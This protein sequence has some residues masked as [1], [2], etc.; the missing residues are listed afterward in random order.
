MVRY[1]YGIILGLSLLLGAG[2]MPAWAQQRIA[3]VIGN[4]D[5]QLIPA[6]PNPKNDAEL[7]ATTLRGLDFEVVLAIDVDG[8]A[9]SRAVRKFGKRLRAAGEDAVGLFF[10]AGHGVAARGTNFL[11]PLGAEIETESDLELESLSASSILSQ[12][13]DARNA[14][15]LVILDACRNNP[16]KSAVRS[17]SGGLARV[18]SAS[19]SLIAFSA[20]PGQVAVDGDGDNSPYTKALV[21]AMQVPGIAIEQVFKRTR[22][23]VEEVTGGQQSPWEE[24]SLRGDFYFVP[25]TAPQAN[26]QGTQSQVLAPVVRDNTAAQTE[27]LFWQSVKDSRDPD[28]FAAYLE[29]Y[30]KGT[31][32]GL[33]RVLMNNLQRKANPASPDDGAKE[34]NQAVASLQPPAAQPALP[35]ASAPISRAIPPPPLPQKSVRQRTL[36]L[37][38]GLKR[39]GCRPGRIDGKWGAKGRRA[40]SRFKRYAGLTLPFD[41][42]SAEVIEAVQQERTNVCPA[43]VRADRPKKIPV[44]KSKRKAKPKPQRTYGAQNRS[45]KEWQ[46]CVI[47]SMV[48]NPIVSAADC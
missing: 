33:A 36:I 5:Y 25:G 46:D 45:K 32:A 6:L 13:V 14:L 18:T 20:A 41:D 47:D 31:F 43:P 4:S 19:G 39:L 7:M 28:V 40:L 16:F 2:G 23:A 21:E 8:R 27:A 10:Y 37:Q 11:I 35:A 48:P 22:I 29:T 12:M 38:R 3:L 42:L 15:N 26:T 30:P 9:M 34:P 24:S 44:A 1:F 17:S